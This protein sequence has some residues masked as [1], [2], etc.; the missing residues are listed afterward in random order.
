MFTEI[1]RDEVSA[2]AFLAWCVETIGLGFHPDTPFADYVDPDTE[3]PVFAEA[4]AR[5]LDRKMRRAFLYC[6]PYEVGFAM[7]EAKVLARS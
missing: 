3:E 1:V 5:K 2:K 6:D 7:F 4:T